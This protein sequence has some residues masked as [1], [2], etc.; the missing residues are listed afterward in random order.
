MTWNT[1]I[2][3]R[4]L[5]IRRCSMDIIE[6]AGKRYEFASLWDRWLGQFLDGVIYL[7]IVFVPSI[8][9]VN[10]AEQA[11]FVIIIAVIIAILYYLFQDGFKNGQSYGKRAVKTRVIDSRSGQPCTFWQSFVRNLLLSILGFIDWLFILG[12]QRQRLGDKA[13]STL[14]VKATEL[15]DINALSSVQG[16]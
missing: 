9:V 13:A 4:F 1:K 12:A 10:L 11:S 3:I 6:V 5:N 16:R 15:A 8:L 2:L 7:A 14:V